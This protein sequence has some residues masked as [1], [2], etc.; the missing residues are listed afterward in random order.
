M[1]GN[2]A[3]AYL[4]TW[5]AIVAVDYDEGAPRIASYQVG[6]QTITKVAA[7]HHPVVRNT[8]V[9]FCDASGRLDVMDLERGVASVVADIGT[10][11]CTP[12]AWSTDGRLAFIARTP[13][14]MATPSSISLD[15]RGTDGNIKEIAVPEAT[16][17]V[18][19]LSWSAD[20]TRIAMSVDHRQI[21]VKDAATGDT[22]YSFVGDLA[23]YAPEKD[24]LAILQYSTT[25]LDASIS[26]YS[27]TSLK[28]RR[29]LGKI[30]RYG[31]DWIAGSDS[32]VVAM[33][34][35][36][37]VWQLRTGTFT[38]LAAGKKVFGNIRWIPP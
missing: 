20:S 7:G 6:D 33:D 37:G 10:N 15:I 35:A 19:A 32:V 9:A 25:D 13:T 22:V 16:L 8:S 30:R 23:R 24:E 14:P 12:M 36:V 28:G 21:I 26:I 2:D 18:T 1:S 4:P 3:L 38:S 5:R 11:S 31:L 17:G 29:D 27:G 34:T